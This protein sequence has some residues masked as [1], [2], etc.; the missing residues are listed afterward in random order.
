MNLIISQKINLLTDKLEQ[1]ESKLLHSNFELMD[2]DCRDLIDKR[3]QLMADIVEEQQ[4]TQ[5]NVHHQNAKSS[6]NKFIDTWSAETLKKNCRTV[7]FQNTDFCNSFLDQSIPKIWNF[8]KDILILVSPRSSH[9]IEAANQRGQKHIIAYFEVDDD[10]D[11]NFSKTRCQTLYVCKTAGDIKR[12]FT[13]IQTPVARTA[14]LPASPH[15]DLNP[16]KKAFLSEAVSSGQKNKFENTRAASKF[17]QQ[18]AK[19]ILTNLPKLAQCHNLHDISARNTDSAIV[20]ASGPSLNK[21][22]D[23][24]AEIQDKVLVVT[25]LRSM[26]V[27]NAAGI[28]PDIV[29]QLD[30]ETDEVAANLELQHCEKIETFVFEPFIS[31]GFLNIPAKH[32]IWSLSSHFY[33]IHNKF[34]TKPTPF[35]VP[36]VSIYGLHL[37]H[38]IGIKNL[39]FI[40]QDLAATG[41]KQYAAGATKLLPSNSSL[42]MFN[43]E[44][45]GF[46]GSSVM[47]RSSF[48]YQIQICSD[49]AELWSKSHPDV[50]LF[51]ATEGGAYIDGFEHLT[52]Q[53]FSKKL[54]L[55]EKLAGKSIVLE[56]KCEVSSKSVNDFM[57]D[58]ENGMCQITKIADKISKLDK[59]EDKSRGLD[60][61]IR[62]EIE[63]FTSINSRFS[64]LQ[65]AMQDEIAKVAGTSEKGK[66]ASSY[67]EFFANVKS[68][69]SALEEISR[70]VRL[71]KS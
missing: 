6:I 40:G 51:N 20:V 14:V 30:A 43:V 38:H 32:Y 16:S 26:P 34:G 2:R 28:K 24:L 56:P 70:K 36:S 23:F 50:R 31:P 58:F 63:K 65:T 39:C 22:I 55:R 53:E 71:N 47:T 62:R 10:I 15:A 33:D 66:A 54:N 35:N 61:K 7:D 13:L 19:N 12:V 64:L 60:K 67:S 5:T 27:L 3:R 49:I 11:D 41:D 52:L 29:V 18:W 25:A 42:S 45:P 8:S 68:F 4:T 37:C 57:N 59:T 1:I 46:Y 17:G 69:A 21:N 44:V 9:L 48:A